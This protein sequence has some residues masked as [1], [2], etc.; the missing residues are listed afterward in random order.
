M[1]PRVARVAPVA[2]VATAFAVAMLGTTLPTPLYPFLEQRFGFGELTTTVVF[3]VYPVGVAAALLLS[4]HWSDQVGRRPMLLAGLGLSAVSAV[5]FL[6]A[7]PTGSMAWVYAARLVSGLSA[8]IFTGTATAAVVDLADEGGAERAGL[9]AAAAN[10]GGL[11]LG[12]VVAGLLAQW[13][14]RPLV[15]PFVVDLVLVGV[16]LACVLAQPETVHRDPSARLRPQRISVP[17]E[18]R[19]VFLRASVAGFAGFAVLGLFTAVSPA[20]L[21]QVLHL[22]SPAL[23][24]LV[25]LLVFVASIAGQV[26]SLRLSHPRAMTVGCLALTGGMV[27]LAAS[28]LLGQLVLLVLGGLVAGVGQGLTFRAGLGAVGQASPA[29]R[30]GAISSAYF[31]VLYVGISV[32][33]VGVGLLTTLVGLVT[34]GV[35]FAVLVGV[36]TTVVLVLLRR[37]RTSPDA[38]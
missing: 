24:G 36:L 10:M 29:A 4:G 21:G 6:L 2:L 11:G 31:V 26:L 35:V 34:A 3:A 15:V 28:L 7:S 13:A 1:S 19:P 9:V 18:V 38:H 30:R 27:V 33:V 5:L 25:V 37:D 12:P 22:R 14:P 8:G 32:P 16:A 20:F 17:G 23:V